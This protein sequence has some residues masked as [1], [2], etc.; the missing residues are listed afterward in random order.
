MSRS[1]NIEPLLGNAVATEARV[2][3][4]LRQRGPSSAA[5]IA[6]IAGVSKSSV[7]AALG[8]L[9]QSG[10][11]VETAAARPSSASGRGRPATLLSLNP[12]AGSCVGVMLGPD[13]IRVAIADV[14]HA[15]LDERSVKLRQDYQV[16]EGVAA[17]VAL[18]DDAYEQTGLDR[19]HLL[20][21]GIA[22][23]GPVDV[24]TGRIFRS[25]MI[26][27]WGGTDIKAVFEPALG[28]PVFVDNESNC[29]AIAEM[30]WGAARGEKDFLFYKLDVGIGG[31]LVIRDRIIRG[32]AGGAGELGHVTFDPHGPL[33]RCGNRGC[34]ELY[35][36]WE[37]VLA[38][39]RAR[40]GADVNFDVVAEQAL[41]GD[42]GCRKLIED[43]AAVAGR[44]LAS[45]CSVLNP[46]L[47]ILGGRQLVAAEIIVP[48]LR[49]AFERHALIKPEAVPPASRTR[50]VQGWFS[51]DRHISLGAV[52]LA[53]RA[54]A[55]S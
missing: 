39:A 11:V 4:V 8:A 18:V 26:P 3:R 41:S 21:V 51:S 52:G 22:A 40:F 28:A 42:S 35:A 50:I 38:P 44:G 33:C 34:L 15:V 54:G 12:S 48:V 46:P 49:D 1:D 37:A 23:P 10:V 27:V 25:S 14:S 53:L 36:G 17:V 6:R 5:E 9:R 24:G 2:I 43:A 55:A 19:S 45:I 30:T 32:A 20:A 47:V 13:W 7:S 16:A 29:T 31:C